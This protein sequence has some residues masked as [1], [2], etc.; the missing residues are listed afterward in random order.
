MGGERTDN[1]GGVDDGDSI[2]GQTRIDSFFRS[3]DLEVEGRSE[4]PQTYQTESNNEKGIP[5]TLEQ[6]LQVRFRSLQF[7]PLT[8][9]Y[10]SSL[11]HGS[12]E[13]LTRQEAAE[14]EVSGILD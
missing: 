10:H 11:C 4:Y 1:R 12:H 6:I 9:S 8:G 2:R 13:D 14:T 5:F 7:D 3:K